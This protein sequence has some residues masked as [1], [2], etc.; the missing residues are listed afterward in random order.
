MMYGR[1]AISMGFVGHFKV[2][3]HASTI[4]T[5]LSSQ[6]VRC[7]LNEKHTLVQMIKDVHKVD[8]RCTG[9]QSFYANVESEEQDSDFNSE[10]M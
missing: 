3:F 1:S 4:I 8:L 6:T 5:F 9:A 10:C 2:Y 7:I